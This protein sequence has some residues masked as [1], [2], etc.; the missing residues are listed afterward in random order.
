MKLTKIISTISLCAL[1]AACGDD[2]PNGSGNG[3]PPMPALGSMMDRVGRAAVSTALIAP[4][5]SDP[6]K[7]QMKDDYNTAMPSTWD[8]FQAE[9]A[10]SLAIYDALDADCGNQLLA[11]PD[12]VAGRYDGLAGALADDRLYVNSVASSCG[13]YLAVEL[14]AT[15]VAPNDDCGGRT[16]GYDVIDVS[17]SAFAI[18]AV[19]GVGDG[20][21][22]DDASPSVSFPFLAAP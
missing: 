12:P 8:S 4:I 2:S 17:Y 15:G 1:A 10:G 22:A 9:I 5:A 19:S 20:V 21:S 6:E 16:P 14:D 18:G 13:Q 3:A 11:G 7:G